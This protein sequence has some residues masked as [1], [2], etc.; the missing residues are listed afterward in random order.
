[1]FTLTDQPITIS[2]PELINDHVGAVVNF[3]GQVRAINA[4]KV[5]KH[6]IYE[7]Y[8]ELAVIE[9]EKILAQALKQFDIHACF[10]QHRVGDLQV[11]EAAVLVWAQATHRAPAFAATEFIIHAIKQH[12]PIWK[13]EFYTD[14]S[15]DWVRCQHG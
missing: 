9:G 12:V 6:L 13:K 2:H 4:G 7:A 10:A 3:V 11:G 14:G 5:V 1:M 8:P 15:I